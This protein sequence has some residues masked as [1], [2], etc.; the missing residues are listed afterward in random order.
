MTTVKGWLTR[1]SM[2]DGTNPWQFTQSIEAARDAHSCGLVVVSVNGATEIGVD[3]SDEKS[4]DF[5]GTHAQWKEH[6]V[7]L[8]HLCSPEHKEFDRARETS[9]RQFAVEAM[10]A[11]GYVWNPATGW[12][13]KSGMTYVIAPVEATEEMIDNVYDNDGVD[14]WYGV[15]VTIDAMKAIYRRFIAKLPKRST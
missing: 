12:N 10:L 3:V 14:G 1:P 8:D 15:D 9:R 13:F 5:P 4:D 6:G 11:M 7:Y 2:P